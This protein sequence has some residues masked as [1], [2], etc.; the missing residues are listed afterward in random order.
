MNDS[1]P[2]ACSLGGDDLSRRLR[3][4]RA[5]GR[6]ALTSVERGRARSVL[7]FD[8]DP[9][10]RDELERIVAAEASCCAFLRL[11]L[12]DGALTIEAPPGG[13]PAMYELV[14]AFA[15]EAGLSA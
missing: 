14:D 7:R 10:H 13:E 11:E 12:S 8:L 6:A 4:I 9:S 2:I 1:L 15:A 5:L 3:E